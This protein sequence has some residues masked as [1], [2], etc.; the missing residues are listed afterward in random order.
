MMSIRNKAL[1]TALAIGLAAGFGGMSGPALGQEAAGATPDTSRWRYMTTVS[2]AGILVAEQVDGR[3][4]RTVSTFTVLPQTH[5]SGVD[6]ILTRYEVNCRTERLRD[7]GSTAFAGAQ[8][9]GNI[10]SQTNGQIVEFQRGTL[11]EAVYYFGCQ[12]RLASQD[13]RVVTGRDAAVAYART[14]MAR[15]R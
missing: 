12:R 10:A 11:F 7:L 4:L 1:R 15:A 6:T 14:Q 2:G 5:A 8:A 13:R 9:R 3:D